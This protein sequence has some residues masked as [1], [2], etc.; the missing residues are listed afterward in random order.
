MIPPQD[1]LQSSIQHHTWIQTLLFHFAPGIG[2]TFAFVLLARL[3]IPFGWPPS[4]ALLLSWLIIG[5]PILIGTLFFQAHQLNGTLSLNELLLYRQPLPWNQYIWLG[6]A[7]DTVFQFNS[8]D[9]SS[10]ECRAKYRGAN[11]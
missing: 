6:A 2:M 5:I 11:C 7:P 10:A 1:T 4:L 3:T 9:D 8:V